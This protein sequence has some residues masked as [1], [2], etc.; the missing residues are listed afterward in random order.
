MGGGNG[1]KTRKDSL[2]GAESPCG[3]CHATTSGTTSLQCDTCDKWYHEGCVDGMSK[4]KMELIKKTKELKLAMI[5]NCD[6]CDQITKGI[7]KNMSALTAR[8]DKLETKVTANKKVGEENSE[9]V[10][11]L[12]SRVSLLEKEKK[13]NE[14]KSGS[15]Q[16]VLQELNDR[17][18]RECNV[19]IHG[20]KE[21]SADI[22]AWDKRRSEDERMIQELLTVIGSGIEVKD[23]LKFCS[24][25]GKAS[26]DS[27]RATMTRPL[28][29]GF[30]RKDE[31]VKVLESAP[32]LATSDGWGAVRIVADLTRLQRKNDSDAKAEADRKNCEQSEEDQKNWLWKVAGTRGN[33][34]VIRTRKDPRNTDKKPDKTKSGMDGANKRKGSG[35]KQVSAAKRANASEEALE[36]EEQD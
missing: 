15:E 29:V 34:R 18:H 32:K 1:P 21:P 13:S 24:R 14:G 3:Y 19:V 17:E 4:E 7:L 33:K 35:Q 9:Q 11:M 25:M 28:L 30:R 22:K 26:T 2:K 27:S 8:V 16:N 36:M 10:D 23:S 6:H 20:L 12:K 31:K 5:W